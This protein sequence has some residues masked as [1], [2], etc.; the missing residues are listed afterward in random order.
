MDT[1]PREQGLNAQ[2][3]LPMLIRRM[4][5]YCPVARRRTN[6]HRRSDAAFAGRTARTKARHRERPTPAASA[7]RRDPNDAPRWTSRPTAPETCPDIYGTASERWPS[8][9]G[10]RTCDGAERS[11]LG[12]RRG[13]RSAT[14]YRYDVAI[15]SPT[16]TPTKFMPAGL[17]ANRCAA[18]ALPKRSPRPGHRKRAP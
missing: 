8:V 10:S 9:Q 7:H 11:R 14:P 17:P 18:P 16:T 1:T 4:E 6:S 5:S 15:R 3:L 2:R 12:A 13:P